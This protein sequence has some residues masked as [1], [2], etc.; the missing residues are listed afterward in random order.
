MRGAERLALTRKMGFHYSSRV[1]V[2]I[3]AQ[4]WIEIDVVGVCKN[5]LQMAFLSEIE[6]KVI[7]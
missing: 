4:I 6:L 3:S 5:S 2:K 7:K 1:K